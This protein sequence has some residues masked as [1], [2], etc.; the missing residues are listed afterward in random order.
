MQC[1][2]VEELAE[3]NVEKVQNGFIHG[4]LKASS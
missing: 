3:E 1:G 4:L 2:P